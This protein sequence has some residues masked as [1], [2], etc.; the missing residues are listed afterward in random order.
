MRFASRMINIKPSATLTINAKVLEMKARGLAVTSLAVGEPNF[1]TPLH[2][3]EAA[4]QAI[5]DGFTRYTAVPGIPELREAV[6]GYFNRTYGINATADCTIVGNGGKQALY[7]LFVAL[8]DSGDEVLV[9]SPYW[10]SYP[11]MIYLNGGI[12]VKVSAP[13]SQNF[14]ITVAQLEAHL[15]PK[16]RILLFNSPSN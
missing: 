4:Q 16:T 13:A 11:D 3:R 15:T 14:K 1:P 8:L 10:V 7:D 12:P 2:A 6:A 5:R 9:P